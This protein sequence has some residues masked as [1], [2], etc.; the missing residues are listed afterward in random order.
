MNLFDEYPYLENEYILIHRMTPG[1]AEA[2]GKLT[3]D[4][5]V[6]STVPTFLYE[7]KYDDKALVIEREE[8]EYFRTGEGILLGIY[9]KSDPDQMVG[10][11]EIYG[12]EPVKAKASIGDRILPEYWG[13]GIS[14]AAVRLLRD[15]LIVDVGLRTITAHILQSNAASV[16]CVLKNG[17]IKRYEGIYEDWGRPELQLTDK[18]MYKRSYFYNNGVK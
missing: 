9:L 16:S 4:P 11:A 5:R 3:E 15:Y 14:T 7:M 8:E 12:Y 1:D 2:L 18:Y 13:R 6:K 10:L 17:F